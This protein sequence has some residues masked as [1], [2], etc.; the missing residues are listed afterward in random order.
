M[1]RDMKKIFI[2][3]SIILSSAILMNCAEDG[4]AIIKISNM[5]SH[6]IVISFRGEIINV[7]SG[8][9]AELTDLEKGEFEY[10]TAYEVPANAT[11]A[12]AEGE[13]AGTF[14]INA[15]TKINVVYT[16]TF[17]DGGYT[18]YASVTTS[19]DLTPDEDLNPI[20]P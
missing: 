13:M 11:S 18:I 16:S 14:V 20:G 6:A 5:A 19:D 1:S 17:L 2:Y 12:A 3:F 10:E 9:T 15:G 4:A 8:E 7:A